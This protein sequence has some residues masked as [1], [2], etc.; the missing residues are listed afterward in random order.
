M[1]L[2]ELR[3]ILKRVKQGNSQNNNIIF[4]IMTIGEISCHFDREQ[5]LVDKRFCGTLVRGAHLV[6]GKR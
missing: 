5:R 2:D 6:L 1:E 3:E 4:K